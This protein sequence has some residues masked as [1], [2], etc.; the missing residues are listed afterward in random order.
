MEL[1]I[2]N[3]I[4]Q[5]RTENL[6]ILFKII[7]NLGDAVAAIVVLFLALLFFIKIKKINSAILVAASLAF[8]QIIAHLLKYTFQRIRPPNEI[9]VYQEFGYSMPSAHTVLAAAFYSMIMIQLLKLIKNK[10]IKILVTIVFLLI[11]IAIAYSRLYLGVHW[12]SDILVG[13]AIGLI[14]NIV[15]LMLEKPILKKHYGKSLLAK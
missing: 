13:F 11:I 1:Q 9:A 2:L 12:P 4:A 8:S 14:V 15:L 6:T 3:N 7:T 5:I 10:I